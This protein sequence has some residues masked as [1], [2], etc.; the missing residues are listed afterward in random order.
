MAA[1]TQAD[2][3][4]IRAKNTAAVLKPKPK[5]KEPI[6]TKVCFFKIRFIEFILAAHS[7]RN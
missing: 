5:S 3:K 6:T 2:H 4:S 7:R 1:P